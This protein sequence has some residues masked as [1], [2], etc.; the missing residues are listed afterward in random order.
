MHW[1]A[2]GC[3]PVFHVG[4]SGSCQSAHGTRTCLASW[5]DQTAH[6][7]QSCD[8]DPMLTHLHMLL[9]GSSMTAYPYVSSSWAMAC[10]GGQR[11]S[12]AS[13][14]KSHELCHVLRG[15]FCDDR[16]TLHQWTWA[17]RQTGSCRRLRLPLRLSAHRP[18]PS[19]GGSW[20]YRCVLLFQAGCIP[21]CKLLPVVA[22]CNASRLAEAEL[23]QWHNIPGAHTAST[24]PPESAQQLK[25]LLVTCVVTG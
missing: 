18:K 20:S 8:T 22:L 10:I 12:L 13:K 25:G 21:V 3:T 11:S 6:A 24:L 17:L 15:G 4:N 16:R 5:H 1:T 9:P 19:K 7:A 2:L 14:C 23:Q